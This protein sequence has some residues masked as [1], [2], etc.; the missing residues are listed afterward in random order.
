MTFDQKMCPRMSI[1]IIFFASVVHLGVSNGAKLGGGKWLISSL[2]SQ[3]QPTQ[4]CS[5][6]H[7]RSISDGNS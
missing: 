6:R 5:N 3:K 2:E 4:F 1:K 7:Q